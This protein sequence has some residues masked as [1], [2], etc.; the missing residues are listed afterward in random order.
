MHVYYPNRSSKLFLL[1]LLC[2]IA[3]DAPSSA[4]AQHRHLQPKIRAML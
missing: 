3:I 1:N 2:D 4:L